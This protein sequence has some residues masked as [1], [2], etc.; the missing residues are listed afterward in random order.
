[1]GPAVITSIKQIA[2]YAPIII[3]GVK[4]LNE[5]IHKWFDGKKSNNLEERINNIENFEKSQSELIV[6]IGSQ[7]N[8]VASALQL[9]S[10][11]VCYCLVL[12]LLAF[13]LGLA[14]LVLVV[15]K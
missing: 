2:T 4:Q 8:A 13:V 12:S 11:R 6:N 15:I 7:L 3:E 1:M 9:V 5:M 10:K 14:S